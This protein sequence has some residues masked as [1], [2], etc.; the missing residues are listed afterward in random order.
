MRI[1][2]LNGRKWASTFFAVLCVGVITYVGVLN[3]HTVVV[4]S[5]LPERATVG[6]VVNGFGYDN[7]GTREFL[8]S[9][10]RF[11]AVLAMDAPLYQEDSKQIAY[12]G[13]EVVSA[14]A[15]DMDVELVVIQAGSVTTMENSL[16]R[17][18]ARAEKGERI[19]IAVELGE[20]APYLVKTITDLTS[21]FGHINI[22]SLS[23]LLGQTEE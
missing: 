3:H 17:A 19:A 6:L 20:H 12:T 15:S 9:D 23:T 11:T 5:T 16:K 2:T 8:Y 21:A 7:I 13:R 1:M 4:S 22:V 14:L 18:L 10:I